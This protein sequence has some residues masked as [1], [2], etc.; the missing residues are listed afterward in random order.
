MLGA[1]GIA[2]LYPLNDASANTLA[3]ARTSDTTTPIFRDGFGTSGFHDFY[4]GMANASNWFSIDSVEML[5]GLGSALVA[6][7][8]LLF[9]STERRKGADAS[10]A[11][12]PIKSEPPMSKDPV[13]QRQQRRAEARRRRNARAAAETSSRL[14]SS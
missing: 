13:E 7:L 12:A 3:L 11:V 1:T 10:D 9:L 5:L 8:A 14:G 6:L 2:L 4:R